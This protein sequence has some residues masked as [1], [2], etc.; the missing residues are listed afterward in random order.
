MVPLRS[1]KPDLPAIRIQGMQS[2]HRMPLRDLRSS[3]ESTKDGCLADSTPGAQALHAIRSF[4]LNKSDKASLALYSYDSISVSA[5][6]SRPSFCMAKADFLT[7]ERGSGHAKLN[8]T[9]FLA[10]QR[11]PRFP[12]FHNGNR[13]PIEMLVP[14]PSHARRSTSK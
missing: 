4:E 5:E 10:Y 3:I 9:F 7:R 12:N 6:A 14:T 11:L 13:N 2:Q 8:S 1:L